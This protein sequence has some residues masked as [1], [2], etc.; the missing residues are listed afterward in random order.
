M[1][2]FVLIRLLFLTQE[3]SELLGGV[4][5]WFFSRAQ[6][7]LL[8]PGRVTAVWSSG[9]PLTAQTHS[10]AFGAVPAGRGVTQP[11]RPGSPEVV[12]TST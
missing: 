11:F 4:A 7:W 12:Q 10:P 3:E 9:L 8:R 2:T 6:R 5:W 1:Q